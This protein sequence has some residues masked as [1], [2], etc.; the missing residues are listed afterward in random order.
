MHPSLANGESALK[1][2]KV[3][4][5]EEPISGEAVLI[6]RSGQ[7][8]IPIPHLPPSHLIYVSIIHLASI[9][10]PLVVVRRCDPGLLNHPKADPDPTGLLRVGADDCD[11]ESPMLVLC[12]G[13]SIWGVSGL[14]VNGLEVEVERG[15][16][17]ELL[18]GLRT[19]IVRAGAG[20]EYDVDDFESAGPVEE[21]ERHDVRHT[22]ELDFD[23][24][25]DDDCSLPVADLE[26]RSA[27]SALMR[28]APSVL[29]LLVDSACSAGVVVVGERD[30]GELGPESVS[31]LA[32]WPII[33]ARAESAPDGRTVLNDVASLREPVLRFLYVASSSGRTRG[34]IS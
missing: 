3:S 30:N 8:T 25:V 5:C 9:Q 17:V 22:P 31:I 19:F 24:G 32:G 33:P 11:F 16:L 23:A 2:K 4:V 29:S 12:S 6:P 7:V 10:L 13:S 15:T 20:R 34:T 26:S 28:G 21:A 1:Y 18:L 14:L 27:C